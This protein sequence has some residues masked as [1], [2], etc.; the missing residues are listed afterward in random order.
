MYFWIDRLSVLAT[1]YK[2]QA[3]AIAAANSALASAQASVPASVDNTTKPEAV[4]TSPSKQSAEAT[5]VTTE[6]AVQQNAPMPP[7]PT[8]KPP[9]RPQPKPPPSRPI[10]ILPKRTSS[11]DT[12]PKRTASD[13]ALRGIILLLTLHIVV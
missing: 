13:D 4:E 2:Q 5:T 12:L 1:T 3:A 8:G 11:E 10:R 7:R 6:D 9:S